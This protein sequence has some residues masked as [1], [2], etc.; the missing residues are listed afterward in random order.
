M[1]NAPHSLVYLFDTGLQLVALFEKVG[2]A[3]LE[4]VCHEEQP[5]MLIALSHF[6]FTPSLVLAF[7]D[8]DSRLPALLPF[9]P[10]AA[11]FP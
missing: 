10:L 9:L 4:E 6:Q 8:V 11:V 5:S 3:L 1:R 7:E 2:A